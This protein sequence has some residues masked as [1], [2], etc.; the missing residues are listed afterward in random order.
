MDASRWS[1]NRNAGFAR[2]VAFACTPSL[3]TFFYSLQVPRVPVTGDTASR[4]NLLRLK[5]R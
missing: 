1:I 4:L 2:A 5:I 3:A